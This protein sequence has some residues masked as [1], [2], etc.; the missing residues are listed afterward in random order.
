MARSRYLLISDS[1]TQTTSD[2]VPRIDI[3]TFNI[4]DLRQED[5]LLDYTLTE[6]DVYRFD[7][8]II[9][10]YGVADYYLEMTKW[11][12]NLFEMNDEKIGTTI[13]LYSKSDLDR[14]LRSS[15]INKERG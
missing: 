5:I 7:Q 4:S 8:F 3:F 14:F 12:N 11:L 9:S 2:G 1:E 13:K 15:L 6:N 10:Q